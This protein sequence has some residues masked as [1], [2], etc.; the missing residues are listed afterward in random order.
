VPSAAE[1]E[2]AAPSAAEEEA[3]AT[4]VGGDDSRFPAGGCWCRGAFCRMKHSVL[5]LGLHVGMPRLIGAPITRGGG[6][7]ERQPECV[8]GEGGMR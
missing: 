5:L 8:G 7:R 3:G 6:V 4:L 2:E 1:H